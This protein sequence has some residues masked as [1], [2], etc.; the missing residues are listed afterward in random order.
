MATTNEGDDQEGC[1][2]RRSL[3]AER[4]TKVKEEQKIRATLGE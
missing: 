1:E 4:R 3:A 2:A